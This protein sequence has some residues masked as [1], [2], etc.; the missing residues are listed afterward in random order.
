MIQIPQKYKSILVIL[1]IGFLW[2]S[3]NQ[4]GLI[5][6]YYLNT[7]KKL[8]I[9]EIN[10]LKEKRLNA[11]NHIQKL[12]NNLDYIEFLAY[13]KFKMVKPGEKIFRVKDFK[14]VNE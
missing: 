2:I 7:E 5:K 4:S 9:N 10:K 8:L 13:S 12:Q 3:F 1:F 11:T 6:W 14:T